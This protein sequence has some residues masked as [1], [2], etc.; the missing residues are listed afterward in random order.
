MSTVPSR[1][2]A[3]QAQHIKEEKEK[4][5]SE[6]TERSYVGRSTSRYMNAA[7]KARRADDI[8]ATQTTLAPATT[9][10]LEA[11]GKKNV[12]GTCRAERRKK[13]KNTHTHTHTTHNTELPGSYRWEIE[14]EILRLVSLCRQPLSGRAIAYSRLTVRGP[15]P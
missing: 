6:E 13:T 4:P 11:R 1:A 12:D 5:T 3:S 8:L 7:W 2:R 14:G 15:H 9:C 10:I